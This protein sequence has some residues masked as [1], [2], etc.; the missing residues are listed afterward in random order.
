MR[1]QQSTGRVKMK[2]EPAFPVVDTD[3][4]FDPPIVYS[5]GGLTKRE[6]FAA[7]AMQGL[8]SAGKSV[9]GGGRSPSTWISIEEKAVARADALIKELE[10]D[11]E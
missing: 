1:K 2:N 9:G 8:L 6:Y 3:R 4:E 7:M 5:K 11:D 10:K